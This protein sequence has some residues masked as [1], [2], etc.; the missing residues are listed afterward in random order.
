MVTLRCGQSLLKRLKAPVEDVAPTARLGDWYAR[1]IFVKP[2]QLVLCT[3]EVSLLSVVVPLAPAFT[4]VE[5]YVAAASSRI[6][7]IPAPAEIL[8]DECGRLEDV[9]IGKATNRSVISTM[10]QIT[11]SLEAWIYEERSGD[12]DA[13]GLF[14][15]DIPFTS[16]SK[17]WP[18]LQAEFALTGSVG[19]EGSRWKVQAKRN[20]PNAW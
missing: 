19:R 11:Y 10:N 4:F 13:L 14:L 7:Q 8:S 9:R 6:R 18:W 2:H 3:N 12:L 5:R 16:I 17:T 1:A 20:T 15:C